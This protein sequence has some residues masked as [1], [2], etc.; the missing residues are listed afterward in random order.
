MNLK[1]GTHF[2]H[3]YLQTPRRTLH[4][5]AYYQ[6]ASSIL[7]KRKRILDLGC[8]EGLGTRILV[9]NCDFCL[10]IDLDADAI[11]IAEA[12]WSAG[13]MEFQ[14]ADFFEFSESG[15]DAVISFDVI[16]HIY[17]QNMAL[18]WEKLIELMNPSGIFIVGTPSHTSQKYASAV[19]KE[20]HVNIYDA[21]RLKQEMLFYFSNVFLFC[22]NDE[23]VHTGFAELAHYYIAV[24]CLKG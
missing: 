16:E 14:T 10:G 1:L 17:P 21:V 19:S 6:F 23:L 24:G 8:S 4:Y 3:N 13:N 7:G 18:F 5:L 20:G 11:E 22:A 15:W 9:D 2:T 12:N